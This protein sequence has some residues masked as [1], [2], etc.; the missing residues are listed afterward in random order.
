MI[1]L[2]VL[3]FLAPFILCITI[4]AVNDNTAMQL[5]KELLNI[6]LPEDTY[7]VESLSQ[8]GK[9]WG[10]G[11]GMQYYGA[12]LISSELPLEELKS[13]YLQYNCNINIQTTTEI[14]TDHGELHFPSDTFPDNAYIVEKFGQGVNEFF[15]QADLRGH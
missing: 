13:H 3:F 10:N 4:T 2:A 5:E 15:E 8:A 12:M 14:N 7:V 6:P 1:I 11:N 9:L